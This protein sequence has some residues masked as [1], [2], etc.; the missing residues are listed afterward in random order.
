VRR[1]SLPVAVAAVPPLLVL[2]WLYPSLFPVHLGDTLVDQVALVQIVDLGGPLLASALV[3]L[4]NLA[5]F[6]TWRWFRGERPRPLSTWICVGVAVFAAAGYGVA[7]IDGISRSLAGAPALRVG[8]VQGNLG[9]FEKRREAALVH[10]RYLEQTRE[11]L[12]E[13]ELDLVVWPET[14]YIRG[15]K[16][17]YPISGEAIREELRVPVLF[18]AATVRAEGGRRRTYNSALLIGADGVIR[19]AT[20]RTCQCP[21]LKRCHSPGG[22]PRSKRCFPTPRNSALARTCRRCRSARGGFRPRSAR[23]RPSRRSC[24]RW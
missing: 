17:P 9:V 23:S 10:R 2:E 18:G 16:G 8:L 19:L 20:T 12:A 6:E 7:R 24:A 13:G 15:L 1:R 4:V 3:A 11:L 21:S 14:V 22:F 5:A